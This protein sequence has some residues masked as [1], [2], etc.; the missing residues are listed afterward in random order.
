MLRTVTGF[1]ILYVLIPGYILALALT[2]FVPKTFTAIAFDSGAVATGPM[3]AT[4][5]LPF[6][7][8][9]CISNGGNIMVDAFGAIALITLTPLLT[10]Q[11]LGLIYV[12][13]GKRVKQIERAEISRLFATEGNIIDLLEDNPFQTQ[14]GTGERLSITRR[15]IGK[16][17]RRR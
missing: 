6:A 16:K 15:I 17:R 13:K 2:F 4:F 5:L 10:V 14:T 3:T 9:A 1:N 7:I 11:I 12:I 8:G